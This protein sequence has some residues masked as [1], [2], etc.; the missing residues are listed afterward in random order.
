MTDLDVAAAVLEAKGVRGPERGDAVGEARHRAPVERER[1][2]RIPVEVLAR[3][4]NA[5][6]RRFQAAI[7]NL[8][9]VED[10]HRE[11][12]GWRQRLLQNQIRVVFL[13]AGD[14]EGDP[15]VE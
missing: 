6:Q 5:G 9:A 8:T 1:H 15:G 3:D 11:S 12:G 13:V 4:R 10:A 7:P 2:V 14:G